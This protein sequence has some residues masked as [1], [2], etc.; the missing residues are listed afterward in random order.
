MNAEKLER[1]IDGLLK[2]Y[3]TLCNSYQKR[4]GYTP[5]LNFNQQYMRRVEELRTLIIENNHLYPN[6]KITNNG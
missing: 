1:K 6:L 5:N 2:S 4:R 3:K